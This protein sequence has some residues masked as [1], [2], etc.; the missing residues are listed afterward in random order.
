MLHLVL[1]HCWLVT[2]TFFCFQAAD[3]IRVFHVTGV[4]TCALPISRTAGC[5]VSSEAPPEQT[6]GRYRL[7]REIGEGGMGVVHLAAAPN[8]DRVAI[9]VLRPQVIGDREARARLE[10]EVATMRRVR[11][12]RVAECLDADPW[13]SMPYVVTRF[14]IGIPLTEYV[15]EYGPLPPARIHS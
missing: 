14:V 7:L 2:V 6:L 5:T 4:Q 10:R 3:C 15:A 12:P 11:S 9:K 13:G 1:L 8:G